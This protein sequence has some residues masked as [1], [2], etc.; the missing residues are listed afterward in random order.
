LTGCPAA[1]LAAFAAQLGSAQRRFIK[2]YNLTPFQPVAVLFTFA[3][4]Q[5]TQILRVL[6]RQKAIDIDRRRLGFIRR[7]SLSVFVA[8]SPYEAVFRY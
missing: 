2:L 7:L 1:A 8:R 6:W 5:I 3:L 4:G